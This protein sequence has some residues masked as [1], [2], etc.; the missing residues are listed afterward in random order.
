MT[1]E[2]IGALRMRRDTL[3]RDLS[4]LRQGDAGNRLT[5]EEARFYASRLGAVNTLL[6]EPCAPRT[7][8]T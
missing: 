6:L 1:T 3:Q 2:H 5:E 4:A 7:K 8:T